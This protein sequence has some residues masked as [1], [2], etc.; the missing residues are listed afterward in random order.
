MTPTEAQVLAR[1]D[2]VRQLAVTEGRTVS[3]IAREALEEY[4]A[5]R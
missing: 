4:V 3:Q 1:R 2:A 5:Q